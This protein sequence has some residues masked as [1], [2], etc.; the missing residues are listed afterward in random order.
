ML[1]GDV[2]DKWGYEIISYIREH[3]ENV[4]IISSSNYYGFNEQNINA[5]ANGAIDKTYL[6]E[7]NDEGTIF[8]SQK[9]KMV[10]KIFDSKK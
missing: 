3:D 1:D 2:G 10:R 4:T 9:G 5:G 6:Y 7:W 8:R